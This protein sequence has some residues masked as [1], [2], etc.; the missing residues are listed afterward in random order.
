MAPS[1]YETCVDKTRDMFTFWGGVRAGLSGLKAWV[2]RKKAYG[3]INGKPCRVLGHF[4]MQHCVLDVTGADCAV[5]DRVR[6]E[7]NPVIAGNILPK[8]YRCG[9]GDFSEKVRVKSEEVEYRLGLSRKGRGKRR[10][11]AG[12]ARR[13]CAKVA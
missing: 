3:I 7:V 4:G 11:N 12:E 10:K 6:L 1:L 5:G 13:V 9:A 2:L 8:L